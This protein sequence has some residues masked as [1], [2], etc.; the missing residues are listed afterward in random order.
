MKFSPKIRKGE[1]DSSDSDSSTEIVQNT[2]GL[3]PGTIF[4]YNQPR[5]K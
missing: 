2:I 4:G 1:K 5:Q 3:R